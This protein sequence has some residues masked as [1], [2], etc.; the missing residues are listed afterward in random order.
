MRE[1]DA[2][3][4][5]SGGHTK[6]MEKSRARKEMQRGQRSSSP[7]VERNEIVAEVP[8][9][10]GAVLNVG[11]PVEER[12]SKQT[13]ARVGDEE[14][15]TSPTQNEVPVIFDTPIREHAEESPADEAKA[16]EKAPTQVHGSPKT[17]RT[18]PKVTTVRLPRS[19]DLLQMQEDSTQA[20]KMTSLELHTRYASKK[21]DT[22]VV[23]FPEKSVKSDCHSS[24]NSE[25]SSNYYDP[26]EILSIPTDEIVDSFQSPFGISG[27]APKDRETSGEGRHD[28]DHSYTDTIE[29]TTTMR[30]SRDHYQLGRLRA[31]LNK[32]REL[33]QQHTNDDD[34]SRHNMNIIRSSRIKNVRS[35]YYPGAEDEE[36]TQSSSKA[37]VIASSIASDSKFSH[38]HLSAARSLKSSSLT[39]TSKSATTSSDEISEYRVK[40]FAKMLHLLED[41]ENPK[42]A[43]D[44][45]S[46]H[47][48]GRTR[49]EGT[50]SVAEL[51]LIQKRTEEEMSRILSECNEKDSTNGS[52]PTTA[53]KTIDVLKQQIAPVVSAKEDDFSYSED[54]KGPPPN[55]VYAD[56]TSK[57]SDITSPTAC[58]D[59][60]GVFLDISSNRYV[61]V[62]NNNEDEMSESLA[63]RNLPPL[64]PSPRK[65]RQP[66]VEL[67]SMTSMSL[68]SGSGREHLPSMQ[69]IPEVV[70]V[71]SSNSTKSDDE[72]RN[73]LIDDK[74]AEPTRGRQRISRNAQDHAAELIAASRQV[75]KRTVKNERKAAED[76]FHDSIM[77]AVS[78]A[79]E[80]QRMDDDLVSEV[81]EATSMLSYYETQVKGMEEKVLIDE[82]GN[83][84]YGDQNDKATE[85]NEEETK[86]S[87][88][89]RKEGD[90]LPLNEPNP[91]L[92]GPPSY[93]HCG[94]VLQ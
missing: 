50:Y 71:N 17:V 42:A 57:L 90:T 78:H 60:S 22:Q 45:T 54:E 9:L 72:G 13:V 44:K 92:Q 3:D 11:P 39:T 19:R 4:D 21:R 91:L 53:K 23:A 18:Q 52:P 5:M 49:E 63:D 28:L 48:K 2:R 76:F 67:P 24:N 79:E 20:A 64:P 7:E 58:Q 15:R 33:L 74:E 73:D 86:E 46:A 88:G 26:P 32:R 59:G 69:E 87:A 47:S 43:S 16:V 31:R 77:S 70:E 40:L 81:Y 34:A 56:I 82:E 1:I 41:V 61:C 85:D 94:C 35:L 38:N 30:G 29:D 84:I 51:K 37:S 80:I 8:K 62:V 36:V 68:A 55:K 12:A 93:Q 65:K 66:K 83:P 75:A 6:R 10:D 25:G 14:D 27:K 89:V